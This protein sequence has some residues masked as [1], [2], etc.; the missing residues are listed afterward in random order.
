MNTITQWIHHH[1]IGV[2]LHFGTKNLSIDA[3]AP[4]GAG[5]YGKLMVKPRPE[6]CSA[7]NLIPVKSFPEGCDM[8]LL[9][10]EWVILSAEF[11]GLHKDTA[12]C[13]DT[14]I[15]I[16]WDIGRITVPSTTQER[17]N[18]GT[19][20]H[21]RSPPILRRACELFTL[22]DPIQEPGRQSWIAKSVRYE[23]VMVKVLMAPPVMVVP[24][25]VTQ[26]PEGQ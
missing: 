23:D 26:A 4:T 11:S 3:V 21:L 16:N 24:V 1:F 17:P 15:D 10:N 20:S 13:V 9:S 25:P 22:S 5:Q 8:R 12:V 19:C 6:D 2:S 7:L 14:S 18:I